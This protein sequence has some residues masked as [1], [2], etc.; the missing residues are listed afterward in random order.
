MRNASIRTKVTLAIVVHT[1]LFG[2]KALGAPVYVK[3]LPSDKITVREALKQAVA[4]KVVYKCQRARLTDAGGIG[5]ASNATTVWFAN[6]THD[7]SAQMQIL[8]GGK[9]YKCQAKEWSA[10]KSNLVNASSEKLDEV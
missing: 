9:G 10:E 7:E 5:K 8:E 2:L 3:T 1:L 6:I 4:G